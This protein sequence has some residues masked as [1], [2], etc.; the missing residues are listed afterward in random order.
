MPLLVAVRMGMRVLAIARSQCS[1]R[2]RTH[3]TVQI[4]ALY[5]TE[6]NVLSTR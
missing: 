6:F 5:A 3:N 1:M 2:M 4:R